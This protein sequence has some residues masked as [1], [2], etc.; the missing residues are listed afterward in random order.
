MLRIHKT[1][2][3]EMKNMP[4]KKTEQ[5][6]LFGEFVE[7]DNQKSELSFV[8]MW[9]ECP[10]D[11]DQY[12]LK[13]DGVSYNAEKDCITLIDDSKNVATTMYFQPSPNAK[14]FVNKETNESFMPTT[15][16]VKFI[17]SAMKAVKATIPNQFALVEVLKAQ[18]MTLHAVRKG[19]ALYFNVDLV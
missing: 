11:G 13:I 19:R 17:K 6:N 9:E 4:N 12:T 2:K 18:P 15:D 1:K 3:M 10:S 7:Y 16:G 14:A 8:K 5:T